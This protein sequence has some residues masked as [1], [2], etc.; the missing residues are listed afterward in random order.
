MT[1]DLKAPQRI[2]VVNKGNITDC[3]V[4]YRENQK[5]PLKRNGKISFYGNDSEQILYYTKQTM[6]N[7]VAMNCGEST[8]ETGSYDLDTSTFNSEASFTT[9][10]KEVTEEEAT[11]EVVGTLPYSE[12]TP[13][14]GMPAGNRFTVRF[15]NSDVD[16][17]HLPSGKIATVTVKVNGN[18]TS[19]N[20]YNKNAFEDD[21][22]LV[23]IINAIKDAELTV[24]IKWTNTK[25]MK[26]VF[27]FNDVELGAEGET[28]ESVENIEVGL[29]QA[30]KLSNI[31][32]EEVSF[33]PHKENFSEELSVG[34]SITFTCN[35]AE[36]ALYYLL[37]ANKSIKVELV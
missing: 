37:Q 35:T 20:E 32:D 29:P 31:G 26:Y 9:I 14:I 6:G 27:T 25:T 17:D 16:F 7:I 8:A 11:Y 18:T 3:F 12:A 13:A 34:S 30:V 21:G 4:P 2:E 10:A 15:V 1:N 19:E 23:T 36:E 24:E 33:V 28:F 5:F 22:S